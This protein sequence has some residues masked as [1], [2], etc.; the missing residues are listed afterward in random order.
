MKRKESPN[1]SPTPF[2]PHRVRLRLDLGEQLAEQALVLLAE[3]DALFF[4]FGSVVLLRLFSGLS[5]VE[6]E[7]EVEERG[8]SPS[9]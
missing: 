9:R 8:S 4:V 6:R 3:V 1:P 7:V 2:S 5:V